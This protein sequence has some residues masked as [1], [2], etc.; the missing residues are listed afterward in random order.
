MKQPK[1]ILKSEKGIK[2]IF[3][4]GIALIIII[5]LFGTFGSE[6]NEKAEEGE[7]NVLSEIDEYERHLEARL[8]E[9]IGE[10]QGTRD[11]SVMITLE[12]TEESIY[13]A[14]ETS[15]SAKVTPTVRGV[16]VVCGGSESAV[17][18]QKVTDAVCKAL[19]VSAAKVCV[20]Y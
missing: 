19:G 3:A 4:A 9:I 6:R 11:I 12:K 14:K 13:S 16:L 1:E 20:T 7:K 10:I 2:I 8:S 15:V 17:V 5:F 18:R